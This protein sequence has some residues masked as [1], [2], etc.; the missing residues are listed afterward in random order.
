MARGTRAVAVTCALLLVACSN[1]DEARKKGPPG[2][3][4]ARPPRPVAPPPN[5]DDPEPAPV[6]PT[7]HADI[8]P[9]D[10]AVTY[11]V[12]SKVTVETKEDPDMAVIRDARKAAGD[13]FTGISDGT[14]VR[15]ATIHVVV[16]PSGTVNRSEVNAPGTSESWILSC[17]DGVGSGLHFSDKPKADI[18]NYT[19]SVTATRAH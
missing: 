8:R 4:G 12:G 2:V 15:N 11:T 3:L 5:P 13:C 19:I 14:S 18:R 6:L 7:T 9:P 17:L 16:L 10:A 1:N